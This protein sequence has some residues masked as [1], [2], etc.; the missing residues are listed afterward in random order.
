[1]NVDLNLLRVFDAIY[2]ARNISRAA[3]RLDMSQPAC[4]QALGRLRVLLH[5]PLFERTAGGV[6]PTERAHQLAR[7]VQGGLAMLEEGLR[8]PEAFHPATSRAELKL[9]LT[10]IGEMR[11]LPRLMSTL[12]ERAPGVH[13]ITRPWPQPDIA[14]ALHS[15]ALDLAIGYLPLV[16]GTL[17]VELLKDR[18]ALMVRAGHPLLRQVKKS[19]LAAKALGQFD[20][21]TVRSHS[22]TQRILQVLR[23][24]EQIRLYAASFLALPSIVRST[25][26]A[27]VI[28]RDIAHEF[29]PRNEFVLLEPD[30]PSRD[31]TVSLHYGRR[32]EHDPFLRWMRSLVVELFQEK[33]QAGR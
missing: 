15:Q 26:L 8:E 28:P 32:H 5:D 2:A 31:F 12:R 23:L 9:H 1:M 27:V 3:E 22:E 13:V 24:E 29:E 20:F 21:V 17:K 33:A 10:D 7:S 25:D 30:L 6:K 19:G 18:Y 4:S 16:Q 11:F 14:E